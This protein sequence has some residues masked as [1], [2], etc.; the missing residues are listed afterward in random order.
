[1]YNLFSNC[2]E[3]NCIICHIYKKLHKIFIYRYL[4]VLYVFINRMVKQG[5]NV[6]NIESRRDYMDVLCILT[7]RNFL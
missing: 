3:K 1:M 7:L 6:N 4:Y 5:Q 2:S